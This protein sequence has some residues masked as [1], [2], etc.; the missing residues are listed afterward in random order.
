MWLD[1]TIGTRVN[2][3]RANEAV[4]TGSSIVAAA[5]PFCIVMLTDGVAARAVADGTSGDDG[6]GVEVAD[7]AE[8]LLRSVLP[9]DAPIS[10]T[11]TP[12]VPASG[13]PGG[14]PR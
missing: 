7:V 14:T 9:P 6:T 2:A 1:E 3:D 11:P 13:T 10:T 12:A 4:D 5:C 8:L